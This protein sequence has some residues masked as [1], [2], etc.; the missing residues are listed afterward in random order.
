[1][2]GYTKIEFIID[3]NKVFF[4]AMCNLYIVIFFLIIANQLMKMPN[5]KHSLEFF[6]G[7]FLNNQNFS[8]K[9][10]LFTQIRRRTRSVLFI[11]ITFLTSLPWS[12]KQVIQHCH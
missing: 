12:Y 9:V 3:K 8:S 10:H 6:V 11:E 7:K 5:N 4:E 1:M 2:P